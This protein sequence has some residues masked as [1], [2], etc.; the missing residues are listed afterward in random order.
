M[1]AQSPSPSPSQ[2]MN[3]SPLGSPGRAEA[4]ELV[5]QIV[6]PAIG[7]ATDKVSSGANSRNRTNATT[8]TNPNP[9]SDVVAR[10]SGNTIG[11]DSAESV[12]SL[13]P[14]VPTGEKRSVSL[15]QQR[16]VRNV[17]SLSSL[18]SEG[19]A[20]AKGDTRL[21][22]DSTGGNYGDIS[23]WSQILQKFRNSGH[24]RTVLGYISVP[25]TVFMSEE[26]GLPMWIT[27][28][29]NRISQRRKFALLEVFD[30]FLKVNQSSRPWNDLESNKA[31]VYSSEFDNYKIVD[32]ANV[33]LVSALLQ[34]PGSSLQPYIQP[35]DLH[36]Q[37]YTCCLTA[38]LPDLTKGAF[39]FASVVNAMAS[40]SR[41][42][43]V[44]QKRESELTAS[45]TPLYQTHVCSRLSQCLTRIINTLWLDEK[46]FT[47]EIW[48]DF[49]WGVDDCIWLM[50]ISKL[51]TSQAVLSAHD[52]KYSQSLLIKE[53]A[54]TAEDLGL[55]TENSTHEH[56]SQSMRSSIEGDGA[57]QMLCFECDAKISVNQRICWNCGHSFS[58]TGVSSF[59][60]ADMPI[61]SM[62]TTITSVQKRLAPSR[63]YS[64]G[65]TDMKRLIGNATQFVATFETEGSAS[66]S[67]TGSITS[68]NAV[69]D[70]YLAAMATGAAK[71]FFVVNDQLW[72]D[73]STG[74]KATISIDK[75]EAR[76][77]AKPRD[78]RQERP[79]AMQRS[80]IDL[81]Q[82]SDMQRRKKQ[83]RDEVEKEMNLDSKWNYELLEYE[84]RVA[85][86]QRIMAKDRQRNSR[87]SG[88]QLCYRSKPCAWP[89]RGRR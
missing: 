13:V 52:T 19:S 81:E 67:I 63:D 8:N 27:S 20:V 79:V 76:P 34:R 11:S 71:E 28:V 32:S 65:P 73:V 43:F 41:K 45:L 86:A 10:T 77:P 53:T 72:V 22:N 75:N 84:H 14:T 55:E 5:S 83:L 1:S 18:S 47:I 9:K 57:P 70:T 69:T 78:L 50:N 6:L 56:W 42:F 60:S 38:Q 36:D 16:P 33:S 74:S 88:V 15:S 54:G 31:L 12:P 30:K 89:S 64:D 24:F 48:A 39:S 25:D 44:R 35:Y 59:T 26:I 80:N 23:C 21:A 62:A 37:M 17:S 29:D 7:S 68:Y 51:L 58:V 2:S 49:V 87:P 40:A 4:A 85:A 3:R 46:A 82:F 61:E 66:Y